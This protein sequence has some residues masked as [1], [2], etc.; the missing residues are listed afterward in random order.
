M[1]PTGIDNQAGCARTKNATT[2]HAAASPG[3]RRVRSACVAGTFAPRRSSRMGLSATGR[4]R[5]RS[6]ARHL[7]WP[8]GRRPAT[9]RLAGPGSSTAAGPPAGRRRRVAGRAFRCRARYLH[10]PNLWPSPPRWCGRREPPARGSCASAP[11]TPPLRQPS[12]CAPPRVRAPRSTPFP[13]DRARTHR[14]AT[15]GRRLC[16]SG[17]FPTVGCVATV[18]D[19]R[20]QLIQ[21]PPS[22]GNRGGWL[23]AQCRLEFIEFL[24]C[25]RRRVRIQGVE[26]RWL[27]SPWGKLLLVAHVVARIGEV[28]PRHDDGAALPR[29]EQ[30]RKAV[31]EEAKDQSEV[32]PHREP[33]W[34][35]ERR[36][37]RIP[38]VERTGTHCEHVV[39]RI[40]DQCHRLL[41]LD[42]E[43]GP[44]EK[45]SADASGILRPDKP[46][47]LGV[48][49]ECTQHDAAERADVVVVC[50]ARPPTARRRMFP[51]GCPAP[52]AR[53]AARRP[54]LGPTQH[55]SHRVRCGLR[56]PL[57]AES[58]DL[59]TEPLCHRCAAWER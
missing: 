48:G 4:W 49:V 29:A 5:T 14:P 26:V 35:G 56:V 8:A 32:L 40:V 46:A 41:G 3:S 55:Q 33:R 42:F 43:V 44:G 37:R 7:T 21:R 31:P 23:A 59:A 16:C 24:E 53:R 19:R 9:G 17:G 1:N 39:D 36:R 11:R 12:H 27:E 30:Q 15:T 10:W 22:A 45:G 34:W 52:S 2:P 38:I 25:R 58:T 13:P 57:A 51:R 47:D 54:D 28:E 50:G 20:R 18:V 6:T